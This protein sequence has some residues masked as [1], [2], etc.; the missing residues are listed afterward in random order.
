MSN[1]TVKIPVAALRFM[2]KEIS[3]IAVYIENDATFKRLSNV[4]K[5]L[6]EM[7]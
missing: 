4:V 1:D 3:E 2:Q 7:L 6:N 5:V